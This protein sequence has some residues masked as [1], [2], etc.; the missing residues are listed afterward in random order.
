MGLVYGDILA[1]KQAFELAAS[2]ACKSY[3]ERAAELKQKLKRTHV[4]GKD[5]KDRD[6]KVNETY[7]VTFGLKCYEKKSYV[8]K[9][10]RSFTKDCQRSATYDELHNIA[11]DYYHVQ[12]ATKTY[13]A[14]YNGKK[15][16]DRLQNLERYVLFQKDKKKAVLLYLYYP[17]SHGKLELRK[18]QN[19]VSSDELSSDESLSLSFCDDQPVPISDTEKKVIKDLSFIN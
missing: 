3:E 5:S 18:L 12:N 6:I 2:S 14:Q 16:G 10:N 4:F 7:K 1:Y 13:L 15:I 17:H 19:S 11:R 9:R 8:A